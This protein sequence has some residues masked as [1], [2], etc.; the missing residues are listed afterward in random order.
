M[1]AP[2]D[3]KPAQKKAAPKPT[4]HSRI[5]LALLSIITLFTILS[6]ATYHY[7]DPSFV[8]DTA[9]PE[10][11]ANVLG[12][13][14]AHWAALLLYFFGISA[15]L[16]PVTMLYCMR[17]MLFNLTWHRERDRLIALPISLFVSTAICHTYAFECYQDVHP[18]GLMGWLTAVLAQFFSTTNAELFLFTISWGLGIVI[19]RFSSISYLYPLAELLNRIP[20]HTLIGA[21]SRSMRAFA[22]QLGSISQPAAQKTH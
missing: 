7:S 6:L 12:I 5:G 18:G 4:G 11:S 15:L 21:L 19:A 2:V 20:L 10:T 3:K 8:F 1:N 14:G 22:A 9:Y 16:I 13:G 17:I